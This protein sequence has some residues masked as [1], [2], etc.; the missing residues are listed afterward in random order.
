MARNKNV[1]FGIHNLIDFWSNFLCINPDA[2]ISHIFWPKTWNSKLA[3]PK[4][5]PQD[6]P[7]PEI[8]GPI[9]KK[10]V[11]KFGHPVAR[12]KNVIFQD[13]GLHFC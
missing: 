9:L 8:C 10:S 7:K 1:V 3:A 2:Q 13:C 4:N 6:P 12:K 5:P 11:S